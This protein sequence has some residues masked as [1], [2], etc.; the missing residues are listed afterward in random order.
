MSSIH[1]PSNET[2][3]LT[4]WRRKKMLKKYIALTVIFALALPG[5]LAVLPAAQGLPSVPDRDRD[6]LSGEAGVGAQ[7]TGRSQL[8]LVAGS[9]D[10]LV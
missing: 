6:L 3:T 2:V 9:F 4:D 8:H 7:F 1:Y 5:L 10:P